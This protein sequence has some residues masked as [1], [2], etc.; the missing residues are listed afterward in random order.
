MSSPSARRARLLRRVPPD[1]GAVARRPF[2]RCGSF[3]S[4]SSVVARNVWPLRRVMRTARSPFAARRRPARRLAPLTPH[5]P[6][7]SN[8]RTSTLATDAT[9]SSLMRTGQNGTATN[10][11]A[12]RVVMIATPGH[13]HRD[14]RPGTAGEHPPAARARELGV[15]VRRRTPASGHCR[16]RGAGTRSNRCQERISCFV[17][18]QS[19]TREASVDP[20]LSVAGIS[21]RGPALGRDSRLIAARPPT[22]FTGSSRPDVPPGS[23]GPRAVRPPGDG[24]A[25]RRRTDDART[26]RREPERGE[27]DH[28]G[29]AMPNT[30]LQRR[31]WP[32]RRR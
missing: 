9:S 26:G 27:R 12:L 8:G 29:R 21:S 10:Q 24:E 1:Q 22:C 18:Q 3:C 32:R 4:A 23:G 16:G 2:D 17:G 20:A 25:A 28:P 6:K 13:Q 11:T 31:T 14:D 5:P 7:S 15:R 30:R 19:D